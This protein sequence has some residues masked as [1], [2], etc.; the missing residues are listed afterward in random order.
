MRG[1][2]VWGT[3]FLLVAASFACSWTQG[4]EEVKRNAEAI[5][6]ADQAAKDHLGKL[7]GV[8]A[9]VEYIK[10]DAVESAFPRYYLFAVLFPQFPVGRVPP[11][12][13]K[14]SNLFAVDGEG[15]V[16]ALTDR[17]G[18]EKFFQANV[19]AKNEAGKKTAIEAWLRLS[20]Q[21]HQDGFYAFGLMKDALKVEG[22]KASGVVVAMRGGSGTLSATLTFDDD[23]KLDKVSEEAKLRRGPRPICQ[24]TKLLDNDLL[25]RRMAEEDLLI[26]GSAAREYLDEQ[27]AKAAPPLQRAI[28]R[29]WQRILAEERAR[30]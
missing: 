5:A 16:T 28:D 27:R 17:A 13:L 18:L 29:I 7:K 6:K 4:S 24:A 3:G 10:D 26:M 1:R 12:D 19:T 11:K 9:R 21:Y 23:G 8:G 22:K 20:Q 2:I 15:K 25:V 14:A 30:R